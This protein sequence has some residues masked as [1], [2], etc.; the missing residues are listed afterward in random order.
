MYGK[1]ESLS[2]ITPLEGCIEVAV[3]CI[4]EGNP[5]FKLSNA[6]IKLG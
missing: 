2:T 5:D 1:V 3:K 4:S 6:E